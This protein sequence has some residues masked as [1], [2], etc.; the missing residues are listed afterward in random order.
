MTCGAIA[1]D[2]EEARKDAIRQWNALHK[3]EIALLEERVMEIMM[4]ARNQRK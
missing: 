4:K 3:E 1:Y 2:D